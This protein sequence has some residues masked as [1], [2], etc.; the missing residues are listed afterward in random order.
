MNPEQRVTLDERW[1]TGWAVRRSGHHTTVRAPAAEAGKFGADEKSRN[2]AAAAAIK[3]N[4]SIPRRPRGSIILRYCECTVG[5]VDT[6]ITMCRCQSFD[7]MQDRLMM[8]QGELSWLTTTLK[9]SDVPGR[10]ELDSRRDPST[11]GAPTSHTGEIASAAGHVVR[12]HGTQIERYYGPGTLV[13]LCR[14]LEADL[15]SHLPNDEFV[16]SLV[17]QMLLD[18]TRTE[19]LDLWTRQEQLDTSIHLPP[20]QLLSAMLENFLKYGH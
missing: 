17:H 20:R 9:R 13:A 10:L 11:D 1:L 2:A 14:D 8:M 12:D 6:L 15:A 4:A 7:D 5:G 18:S 3:W 16:R 19:N